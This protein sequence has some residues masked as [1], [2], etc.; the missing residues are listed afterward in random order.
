MA[1]QNKQERDKNDDSD[2]Q[3][4]GA[5]AEKGDARRERKHTGQTRN[6][7]GARR[8]EDDEQAGE[9]NRN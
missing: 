9:R 2:N 4:K 6:S 5:G 1:N 7:P 3:G 8:Q